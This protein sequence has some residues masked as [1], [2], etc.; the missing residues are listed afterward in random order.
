[1]FTSG[2]LHELELTPP[3]RRGFLERPGSAWLTVAERRLVSQSLFGPPQRTLAVTLVP[4]GVR[5]F[6]ETILRD[7]P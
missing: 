6:S 3:P 4:P 1:M 5:F 7:S 2:V